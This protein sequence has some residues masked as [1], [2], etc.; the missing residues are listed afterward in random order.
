MKNI[1]VI[2]AAFIA[3]SC[4]NAQ[5]K[6]DFGAETL[7]EK[8]ITLNGES[9]SFGQILEKHKGKT[10]VIA[11]WAS[12][13]SDCVK[14]M[15][16]FKKLQGANPNVEYV[17]ISM[18]RAEDK[19]RTGVKKHE[20]VGDHYF[21]ANGM[22]GSFAKSIDLDWIPRYIVVDKTG[23]IAIYRAIETDFEQINATLKTL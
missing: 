8:L 5:K 22:K 14:A 18:D 9:S 19:W 10:V 23:K 3:A 21:S 16:N 20:L 11:V 1:I 7:D 6:T 4:S 2:C 17:Y 12:W 15:P 13:C